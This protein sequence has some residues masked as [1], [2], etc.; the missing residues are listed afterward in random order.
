MIS[1]GDAKA[2]AAN[3][4]PGDMWRERLRGWAEWEAEKLARAAAEKK[5]GGAR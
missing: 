4:F 1:S 3:R 5:A 2:I